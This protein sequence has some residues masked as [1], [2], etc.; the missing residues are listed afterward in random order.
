MSV[1]HRQ[2]DLLHATNPPILPQ[3]DATVPDLAEV[4]ILFIG[5]REGGIDMRQTERT[6][7]LLRQSAQLGR[8]FAARPKT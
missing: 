7:S 8:I 3:I 6:D 1:L 5:Q 2:V 4:A